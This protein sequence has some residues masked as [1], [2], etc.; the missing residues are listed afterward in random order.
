MPA[1]PAGRLFTPAGNGGRPVEGEVDPLTA[2]RTRALPTAV[3]MGVALLLVVSTGFEGS[4]GRSSSGTVASPSSARPDGS[5][6]RPAA[7]G[8]GEID[9]TLT[10]YNQSVGSGNVSA[11][12]TFPDYPES[13]AYD[14]ANGTAWVA[15]LNTVDVVNATTGSGVRVLPM[16]D[17]NGLAYVNRTDTVWITEGFASPSVVVYNATT[18]QVTRNVSVG[19]VPF[20]V[21]YDW[22]DQYVDVVND[23]SYNVTI[24][25]ATTY[26]TVRSVYVGAVP[27]EI[28]WDN[29][30]DRVYVTDAAAVNVT[31]FS[32]VGTGAHD[33]ITMTG[34][35]EVRTIQDDPLDH[36]VYV[37]GDDN[38]VSIIDSATDLVVGNITTAAGLYNELDGLAVDTASDRLYV[39]YL[40]ANQVASY[41][42]APTASTS[43]SH[44]VTGTGS[45]STPTGLAYDA[46][47]GRILVANSNVYYEASSN[48]TEISTTTG[49]VVGSTPIVRL[50]LGIAYAAPF[51]AIFVYDGQSGDLYKIDDASDAIEASAFVGYTNFPEAEISGQVVYDPVNESLFVDT[52]S[53]LAVPFG[54]T[55][56]NASSMTV[57]RSWT[58]GF[59]FP[60]G[61]AFDPQQHEVV[62]ANYYADNVTVISTRNGA[63]SWLGTGSYPTGVA[64]DPD[65]DGIYVTNQYDLNVTVIHAANRTAVASVPVGVS[66]DALWGDLWD[67]AN[68]SI[69]VAEYVGTGLQAIS[70]A[71]NATVGS[72]ISLTGPDDTGIG[73]P[74]WLA[75]DPVNATILAAEPGVDDET[76]GHTAVGLVNASNGTYYGQIE[77][78]NSIGGVVYDTGTQ[79]VFATATFPGSVYEITLGS[80]APPPPPLT[81][82]LAA[83]PSSI[84]L[85]Q[86]TDLE[87]STS[88]GSSPLTYNYST[89]PPGCMSENES[90]LPCA[91]SSSGTFIVGVNV[92]DV[93]GDHASATAKLVV[94]SVPVALQVGLSAVPSSLTL[95][96]STS[97][98]TTVSGGTGAGTYTFVYSTPPPG[99]A[100]ANDSTLPC[101]PTSSGTY[102][103][104]VN[105]TDPI[106]DHGAAT[107]RVVVRAVG[108]AP[109]LSISVSALPASVV[110]GN[111][112]ELSGHVENASPGAIAYDWPALPP[113]CSSQNSSSLN[114][115]PNQTGRFL[116]EIS[117]RDSAGQEANASTN[118]TVTSSVAPP[119][120]PPSASNL[121]V[122]VLIALLVMAA[123][124]IVLAVNRRRKRTRTPPN[125]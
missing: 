119:P 45:M 95:G 27:R 111:F 19:R 104:G 57:M 3:V 36:M 62:V 105:V 63:E 29:S 123:I 125:S 16:E 92:T 13:I 85:G 40:D 32:G 47:D 71:T 43:S 39:A 94:N 101:T 17:V 12:D 8:V 118:V 80:E 78:G 53:S 93:R 72:G 83:I 65:N 102:V 2:V 31:E 122:W 26:A 113:G 67:P 97:L 56:V 121:W 4:W 28:A 22:V 37:S 112:T 52:F 48:V 21:A 98:E 69:Y 15:S 106:G 14:T 41:Q 100:S 25:N 24:V 11:S 7:V 5:S 23:L 46:R 58:D 99:C 124:V 50:P 18:Y 44:S 42:P 9:R 34:Q 117:A 1:Y 84:S 90:V 77:P 61:I 86:S 81:A 87:T 20:D 79:T 115:T 59:D 10:L 70:G 108:P 76:P 30:T 73:G 49:A 120:P 68:D 89:P 114:C 51:N 109:A 54:V 91:P 116:V 55:E 88:G 75:Y 103:V 64:F 74:S 96:A 6:V 33:S 107:T 82:E 35:G 60:A 110:L 66:G 38:G